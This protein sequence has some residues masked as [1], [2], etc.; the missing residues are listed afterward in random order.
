MKS[1]ISACIPLV[2]A[3]I[4]GSVA[5]LDGEDNAPVLEGAPPSIPHAVRSDYKCQHCHMINNN[6]GTSHLLR[7]NCQQCHVSIA[8]NEKHQML[9][10]DWDQFAGFWEAGKIE[11][12]EPVKHLTETFEGAPPAI[13]HSTVWAS[14]CKDCHS[15]DLRKGLATSHPD[16]GNCTQCHVSIATMESRQFLEMDPLAFRVDWIS[17]VTSMKQGRRNPAKLPT[18]IPHAIEGYEDCLMCHSPDDTMGLATT[19]PERK[20]CIQCHVTEA[21][22]ED[23]KF[24]TQSLIELK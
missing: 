13:P 5:A 16:R 23:R 12:S 4:V 20:N 11:A 8:T 15:S 2:V 19:H 24:L 3:C 17:P 22:T 21:T 9:E 7:N 10:M 1:P 18:V 6:P 14:N